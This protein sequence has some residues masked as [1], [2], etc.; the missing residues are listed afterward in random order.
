M[1]LNRIILEN[2]RQFEGK[3]VID[4]NTTDDKNIIVFHGANGAGK[5]TILSAFTWCL[6]GGTLSNLPS[7]EEYL[8]K[9]I[10]YELEPNEEKEVKVT[11]MFTDRDIPYTVERSVIVKRN[12]DD[13]PDNRF[14]DP[15]VQRN[16]KEMSYGNNGIEKVLSK[17]LQDYFF[18][19]GEGVKKL[20]EEEGSDKVKLGIRN[21]MKIDVY[22]TLVNY[23]KDIKKEYLKELKE[24]SSNSTTTLTTE[25]ESL[26]TK[27]EQLDTI[28]KET[29]QSL[30]TYNRKKIHVEE[31]I[32][33]VKAVESLVSEKKAF[34]VLVKRLDDQKIGLEN[35]EKLLVS[36][37]SYLA[38]SNN[39]IH[40]TSKIL[41]EK[42]K[43]GLPSGI[44]NSFINRLLEEKKCICGSEFNENDKCFHELTKFLNSN[45]SESEI[46]NILQDNLN[47]FISNNLNPKELFVNKYKELKRQIEDINSDLVENEDKILALDKRIGEDMPDNYKELYE[48]QKKITGI[49]NELGAKNI[50]YA[51]EIKDITDELNLKEKELTSIKFEDSEQQKFQD[52]VSFCDESIEYLESKINTDTDEIKIKLSK[53]M[54]KLFKEILHKDREAVIDDNFQLK[55]KEYV[56]GT[57]INAN[58]SDGEDQLVSL[59]FI[60]SLVHLAK[61]FENSTSKLGGAGIYPVVI[62]APFSDLDPDYAEAIAKVLKRMAPQVILLMKHDGWNLIENHVSNYVSN[63]YIIEIN[64]PIKDNQKEKEVKI[65]G[66]Y[67]KLESESK[68]EFATIQKI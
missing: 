21:I 48:N 27:K 16:S 22:E 59:L 9:N 42:I 61:E 14:K 24:I 33:N 15:I 64:R 55:I 23:L 53:I 68:K 62:D 7:V 28:I 51:K 29:K 10:F 41:K 49:L 32:L 17:E 8:S 11:L 6:Y 50:A 36:T 2:F 26:T 18:F 47:V 65:D 4:L 1:Q 13:T 19:R 5:T 12:S 34:E 54:N 57:Q 20:A 40:D 38:L 3:H 63:H 37:K 35:D 58:K 25:I 46:E 52:R 31:Q 60:A 66:Q 67:H 44:K 45:E 39:L 30:T 56:H 43:L